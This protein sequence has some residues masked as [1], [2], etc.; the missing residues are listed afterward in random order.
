M[1]FKILICDF[2]SSLEKVPL[3]G[4]TKPVHTNGNNSTTHE[5]EIEK[6]KKERD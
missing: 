3:R 1:V 5:E 4:I 2:G 6:R